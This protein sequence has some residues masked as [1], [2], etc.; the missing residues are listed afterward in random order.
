MIQQA[1]AARFEAD[2]ANLFPQMSDTMPPR[3]KPKAH[4]RE[5]NAA[6]GEY[7][8]LTRKAMYFEYYGMP[9]IASYASKKLL[10]SS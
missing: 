10:P 5:N 2:M 9:L 6:V 4:P 7:D 3:P 8:I 1:N